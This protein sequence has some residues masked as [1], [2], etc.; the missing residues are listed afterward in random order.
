[1]KKKGFKI[2]EIKGS[3]PNKGYNSFFENYKNI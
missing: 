2:K 3:L 1:M